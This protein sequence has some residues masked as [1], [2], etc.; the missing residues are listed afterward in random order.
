VIKNNRILKTL[1]LVFL[2]IQLFAQKPNSLP[3]SNPEA[4]GVSSQ[5]I[6]DFLDAIS[7]SQNEF[8]SFMILRH[9]KIIAQGWWNP[10]RSDLKHTMYSVSKSFTASAIGF[11]IAE[12][13]LSVNDKVISF[14]PDELP[15]TVGPYLAAL[16]VKDLLSMSVGMQPDPTGE[17]GGN[18]DD[19]IKA[20]FKTPIINEPGTK[21]LYNSAASFMLSAIVQKVTG[22]K[23]LDYLQL[24]LFNPLGIT[25]LD[26]EVNPQ[27]INTGGWGL[28]LKTEDMAKFGQLFLQKGMWNGK[29][30]LPQSWITEASTKKI[31]QDPNAPQA[32][33]DSSDWLQGYC[34]QMWR[35][36]NNEYRGDGAFGQYII[37]MPDKDAVVV[38]TSETS[39]MQSEL[40][41]VWK[42]LLPSFH[43]KPIPA[44]NK[45]QAIL[46][47]KIASLALPVA[48]AGSSVVESKI[49]GKTFAIDSVNSN[50]KSIHFEFKNG[51]C[52]LS[53]KTDS[54]THTIAFGKD[55]WIQAETT[56]WGPYLVSK[57]K[58]NRTNISSFRIAGNYNWKDEKTLEL[59]LRYIESP[60]TEIIKCI[61]DESNMSVDFE[62]SFNRS[63]K[64]IYKGVLAA[65]S[66]GRTES[67]TY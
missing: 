13:K 44:D 40:N 59:T 18:H 60:H 29:Q 56:K 15:D 64:L 3:V 31:D 43:D 20:F 47:E 11:A 65:R 9:G 54:V 8:H 12:K 24:K 52:W 57:L 34:Y 22:K 53:L 66:E 16:R 58:G 33:K 10:Y 41:L 19:W 67:Y 46:K 5:S 38:I 48:K 21:F 50:L 14:F 37:V 39:N 28:R 7:Q 42:Y 4:Q 1:F 25:G 49:S 23:T 35:C 51:D 32:K 62:N 6:I 30:I 61:F 55:K 27:G 26:W 45:T 36:R 17:I 2:S 63:D